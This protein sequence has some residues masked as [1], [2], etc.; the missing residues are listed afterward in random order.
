M[1]YGVSVSPS[2]ECTSLRA[3]KPMAGVEAGESCWRM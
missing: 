3:T 2:V 1:S